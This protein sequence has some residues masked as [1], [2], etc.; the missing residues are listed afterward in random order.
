MPA[1]TAEAPRVAAKSPPGSA[2]L[3]TRSC[4]AGTSP[5]PTKPQANATLLRRPA[6]ITDLLSQC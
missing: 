5:K 4:S 1:F 3:I 2:R 6:S